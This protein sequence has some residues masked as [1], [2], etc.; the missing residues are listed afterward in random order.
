ML[1][2]TVRW[3]KEPGIILR[4]HKFKNGKFQAEEFKGGDWKWVDG[5]EGLKQFLRRNWS[6]RMSDPESKQHRAPSLIVRRFIRGW[7]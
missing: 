1:E 3:G 7:S 5:E 2:A 6:I 4:P